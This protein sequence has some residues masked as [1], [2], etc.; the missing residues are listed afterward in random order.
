MDKTKKIICILVTIL[1]ILLLTNNVLAFSETGVP[2]GEEIGSKTMDYSFG[3]V[4]KVSEN[5]MIRADNVYCIAHG[6]GFG[7]IVEDYN[8]DQGVDSMDYK[9]EFKAVGYVK[10]KGKYSKGV[11]VVKN[12]DGSTTQQEIERESEDNQT[13]SA[14]LGGA[15]GKTG[16]GA[17]Y[18]QGKNEYGLVPHSDT[19][20]AVWG[21]WNKWVNSIGGQYGFPSDSSNEKIYQQFDDKNKVN[22]LIA[23]A[24]A[25]GKAKDYEVTIYVLKLTGKDAARDAQNLILVDNNDKPDTPD[26]AVPGQTTVPGY[27]NISGY[28]WEDIANSKNNTINSKYDSKE[29]DEVSGNDIRLEGIKVHWKAN[30]GSEIASTTTGKDGGYKLQTTIELYNHPYGDGIKDKEKYDKINN[31]YIEFEYNGLKYTTVAYNGNLASSD[32]SKGKE[33]DT[34]RTAVDNKFDR[35]ENRTVYDGNTAIISGLPNTQITD[36]NYAEEFAVSASTKNIVSQLL[37]TTETNGWTEKKT[38]CTDHCQPGEGP[39][40]VYKETYGD[41]YIKIYCN[42]QIDI[43][44]TEGH[45]ADEYKLSMTQKKDQIVG[46]AINTATGSE[47]HYYSAGEID[48]PTHRDCR[49]GEEK[50]YVWNIQN[51]NLGLVRREQPDA[52]ITSDIEKVRVIMKN[53]EY[54]YIYGNRGIQDNEELFDYKVKFGNKY[55]EQQYSRP[56]NPADIAYVNYNNSDDLK[57]YV[58]YN[59][60]LKNQSNTLPMTIN[61]IVNYYDSNYTIYKGE[62][63]STSGGWQESNETNNGYKIAYN[64]SLNN[65]QLQPGEKS[66]VIKIEFEVNQDR[67]KGLLNE[68][69]TLYNVSEIFSFTTYYGENT[70]CA[71][72]ETAA[73]KGKTGKQ[74]AGLDIDSTPGTATPGNV[75]TYEDDTDKAPSFLLMKNQEQNPPT[76][77][78]NPP[79]YIYKTMSGTVYEDM[80]TAESK[81][82]NER[83]GNGQKEGNEKGVANVKVELLD[84]ETG[85]VAYL[86]YKDN[87][88]SAVNGANRKP[89][90][91]YTDANG[92]Y[93]FGDGKTYG[94]VVDNYIIKY[95]YGNADKGVDGNGTI[96]GNTTIDGGN[97]FI[98]ARNYKSTIITESNIKSAMQGNNSEQWHLVMSEDVDTSIAVDDLKERLSIGTLKYNNYENAVNMSAYSKPFEVQVEYTPE[99][100]TKVDDNGGEFP[101]DWSVFDFGIVERPR[102]DIVI[103]KTISKI[104]VTLSNGQVLVEGD[105]NKDNM[106]YVKAIGFKTNTDANGRQVAEFSEIDRMLTI[107]MDSELIQGAKLEIWYSITVTNNSEI[108]YEYEKD[109]TDIIRSQDGTTAQKLNYITTDAQANYYYYG[110][111]NGLT[112]IID[113]VETVADYMNSKLDCNVGKDYTQNLEGVNNAEWFRYDNGGTAIDA[114]YLKD[115]GYISYKNNNE[116]QDKTYETIQDR[117]L[118]TIVT[119]TFADLAPG[120]SKTSVIYANTILVNQEDDAIYD[121]H[122][123]ILEINGK[124]ARTINSVK[125]DTREQVAKTYQ[126]GNYIPT[127]SSD[128][129]QDDDRVRVVVTPPTGIAIYTTT[130]IISAVVGLIVIVGGIV[131]IKKKIIKK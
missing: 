33:N 29:T 6:K 49:K 123:E 109:Y 119:K 110:N 65:I 114:N 129:Q 42:G 128:H 131:L 66:E 25:A 92:N 111:K 8:N 77:P 28:V 36:A 18:Y 120:D 64:T 73:V 61:N 76:D 105:P 71:E 87:S 74:Y 102:E 104:K 58:T 14:I 12:K 23:Q 22:N 59:I 53:Q 113:S 52:A 117:K 50:P 27:I 122:V 127:L 62:G 4:I 67:I 21:F 78:E 90:V 57:V 91:T 44:D 93:S 79:T 121:N 80:Q 41:A 32:T 125:D 69:A 68:D 118:Q 34:S 15:L 124:I 19:Q 97:T 55:V 85:E 95:T 10:I 56:V 51:M 48:G 84:A 1:V 94:V 45:W 108:D 101:E 26:E 103:N 9:F 99:Q 106:N 7:G 3:D 63:T 17:D 72:R 96:I 24:K 86:Y 60:V 35:V 5:D 47:S 83:L 115:N 37:N 82:S 112:I 40:V 30:D 16:Y 70:I 38:F 11:R 98:N 39:H 54:T 2:Q 126:P 75:D 88:E 46:D 116:D 81:N 100:I 31:S 43:H 20:Y 107:E 89:A 13:L 130:Y